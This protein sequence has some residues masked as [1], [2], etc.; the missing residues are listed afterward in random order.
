MKRNSKHSPAF[1]Q[2]VNASILKVTCDAN[3]PASNSTITGM[4]AQQKLVSTPSIPMPER[5]YY[6][7]NPELLENKMRKMEEQ[8]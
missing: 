5:F 1:Y 4:N 3:N 8:E 2:K 7:Q 6:D